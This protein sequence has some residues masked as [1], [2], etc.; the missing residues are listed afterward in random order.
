MQFRLS[1]ADRPFV[2]VAPCPRIPERHSRA[3]SNLF[4]LPFRCARAH[5][6]IVA[7]V[8]RREKE[9]ER[10][11]R[12]RGKEREKYRMQSHIGY[13]RTESQRRPFPFQRYIERCTVGIIVCTVVYFSKARHCATHAHTSTYL[14]VLFATETQ[15]KIVGI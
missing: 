1:L 7:T 10:T 6:A 13:K 11:E 2:P 3:P 8:H 5:L 4:P 15:K 12:K 14:R 9:R